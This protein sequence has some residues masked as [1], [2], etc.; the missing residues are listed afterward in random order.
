[1]AYAADISDN[2][3]YTFKEMLQQPDKNDFILAM[4]KEIQDHEKREHW[5][6]F[7]RAK[8]PYGHKTILAIWSFKRKRFPDGTINKHKSRLCAHGGMQQWGVD[9][10]ETYA[11]VVN[12]LCVR[13]LLILSIIHNYHSRTIDFVLAFPQAKLEE[14]VFM[15]FPAGIECPDGSRKQYVLKLDKN[16]YGLKNAAH[17]WF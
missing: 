15:E 11:P 16:L 1:M 4:M 6:L 10:W 7:P 12:W 2:E 17:D 14:D 8:I 3:T 5:H 13:A 9:Y